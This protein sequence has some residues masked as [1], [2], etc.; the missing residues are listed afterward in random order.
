MISN[1]AKNDI[2]YR[3]LEY[4]PIMHMILWNWKYKHIS[5][6]ILLAYQY[7]IIMG[8]LYPIDYNEAMRGINAHNLAL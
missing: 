8:G 6:L 4:R 2:D 7:L 3:T 5:F 1:K